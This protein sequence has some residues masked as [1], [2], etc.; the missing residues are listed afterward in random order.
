MRSTIMQF[1]IIIIVVV[2]VVTMM[3]SRGLVTRAYSPPRIGL[4]TPA[5]Y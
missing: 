3:R 4:R 5:E 1:I 2:V